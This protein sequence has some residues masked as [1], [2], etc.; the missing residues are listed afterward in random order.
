VQRSLLL[1]KPDGVALGITERVVSAARERG[2]QARLVGEFTLDRALID[3]W[4]PEICDEPGYRV[5]MDG[6]TAGPLHLIEVLADDVF[7]LTRAIKREWRAA[8]GVAHNRGVLHCPDGP[9]DFA[10]EWAIFEPLATGR[11]PALA[12]ASPYPW[13]QCR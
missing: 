4:Y 5:T 13:C 11:A 8:H 9:M 3:A 6:L 2:A 12:G 10:H 7:A 1:V